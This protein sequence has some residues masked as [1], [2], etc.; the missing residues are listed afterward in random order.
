VAV[1]LHVEGEKTGEMPLLGIDYPLGLAGHLRA[2]ILLGQ[3]HETHVRISVDGG[4]DV[5][6]KV[7]ARYEGFAWGHP[8]ALLGIICNRRAVLA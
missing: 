3:G 8:P 1:E 2:N 6:L 7:I 4:Q 5:M